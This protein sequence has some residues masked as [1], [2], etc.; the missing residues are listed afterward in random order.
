VRVVQ[1]GAFVALKFH[2]AISPTRQPHDRYLDVADIASV[3]ARGLPPADE[4]MAIAVA[5]KS[6]PGAKKELKQLIDDMRH[7]R[8]VRI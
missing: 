8:P 4:R 1:R 6:Y 2:A 7:G 5:A 3:V